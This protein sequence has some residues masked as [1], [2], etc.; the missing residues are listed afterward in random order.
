MAIT[1]TTTS[2]LSEIKETLAMDPVA[3]G[4]IESLQQDAMA[5]KNYSL[6]QDLLY[7][8]G[9]IY[10]PNGRELRQRLLDLF[11]G[12]LVGGHSGFSPFQVVY[13]RPSPP[14]V[15]YTTDETPIEALDKALLNRETLLAQLKMNLQRAQ[16]RMP[17]QTNRHRRDK[18]FQ[19]AYRL[20]LPSDAR[21][22]PV[23]HVSLLKFCPNPTVA[24]PTHPPATADQFPSPLRILSKRSVK[25]NKKQVR[26][27]LV[28]WVGTEPA[29]AT[30]E[31]WGPFHASFPNIGLEDKATLD[32][33]ILNLLDG[34][35]I[36]RSVYYF[37]H[38]ELRPAWGIIFC[39]MHFR[40]SGFHSIKTWGTSCSFSDIAQKKTKL[41]PLQ[42]QTGTGIG[43]QEIL[44]R[45]P[46]F[47]FGKG[48]GK[49]LDY[50]Y[51]C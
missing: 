27:V 38:S 49:S 6:R 42:R 43:L 1:T 28:Q 12:S 14:L 5:D 10:V 37:P 41:A 47:K 39:G 9:K 4:I 2:F 7:F 45:V 19:V 17:E 25:E 51:D 35:E 29:E 26:Q 21:I 11:H 18:E 8:N 20:L 24:T 30:W 48:K 44:G 3:K 31:Y 34:E 15:G 46:L 22:H 32:G 33:E 50:D 40:Y 36:A 13:G 23:F 16:E